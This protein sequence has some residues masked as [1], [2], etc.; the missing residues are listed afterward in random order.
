MGMR[1]NHSKRVISVILALSI[2]ISMMSGFGFT[3]VSAAEAVSVST[4]SALKSALESTSDVDITVTDNIEFT[5]SDASTA[6]SNCIS[7][8]GGKKTLNLNGKGV[9]FMVDTFELMEVSG[10]P[11][12]VITLSGS[13]KLYVTDSV[14]NGIL[15][16]VA[17]DSDYFAF[18]AP[19]ESGGLIS[20]SGT[21]LL[22][23]K[24]SILNNAA[25][26]PCVNVTGDLPIVT[27][28]GATLTTGSSLYSW[29]GG[30]ALSVSESVN[31]PTINLLNKTKLLCSGVNAIQS[32]YSKGSGA[33]YIGNNQAA[34]NVASAVFVGTVQ[35]RVA[36]ASANKIPFMGVATHSVKVDE[37]AKT[38]DASYLTGPESY[39][40]TSGS[41][42]FMVITDNNG[43]YQ[44]ITTEVTHLTDPDAGNTYDSIAN[45]F[46]SANGLTSDG[47]IYNFNSDVAG[48]NLVSGTTYFKDKFSAN[49]AGTGASFSV[50]DDLAAKMNGFAQFYTDT[51][52]SCAGEI[53]FDLKM[54][55]NAI[56]DFAGF[57]IKYGDEIV[58]GTSKNSVFFAND[59][60]RGDSANSTT[61]TTGIGFSFRTI[62]G[63]DCIEI[64]VKYLD[65]TG[66]L[67]V[68]SQYFYDVVD[69]LE[70]FN[71]YKVID[72]GE[73]TVELY[74]NGN[75]F[76]E[77][78]CS[79]AKVPTVNT[80]Y[81]E[82]YYSTAKIL[83]GKGATLATVSNALVSTESALAFGTRNEIIEID[84][85][86]ILS[87]DLGALKINGGMLY[88]AN[89]I[90]AI[91][92]VRKDS[93]DSA[94]FT[95]PIVKA[96]FDGVTYELLPN[97]SSVDSKEY[98]AFTFKNVPIQRMND[99]ISA[100]LY[101]EKDG[102]V[103]ESKS[104][105][106]SVA[107]YAYE[108][109]RT[110]TDSKLK[111]LLVDLLNY[112]SYAQLYTKYNSQ[113]LVNAALT[114]EEAAWGTQELRELV[115]SE[116]KP[117][118][119]GDAVWT[120]IGLIIESK[121][122]IMGYFSIPT[123]MTGVTVRATDS[124]GNLISVIRDFEETQGANGMKN[125][126]FVFDKLTA[127]NMSDVVGFT[128]YNSQGVNIS[129]QY[130]FSIESAAQKNQNSTNAELAD[131]LK[132]MMMYGD[133][134]RAYASNG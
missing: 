77:I 78:V 64:F 94:G 39:E 62:N 29:S 68:S 81:K 74:A 16:Y 95:N 21:A 49:V 126:S 101:A 110:T 66:A 26:G 6:T 127:K 59:G 111:T 18:T 116:F 129:G 90:D 85:I 97:I 25:I 57:Y 120:R 50:T 44:T 15:E 9:S 125:M 51:R 43:N 99:N 48:T 31:M 128:V 106:F 47:Y 84:N 46:D 72:D 80:A 121:V 93:F 32:L 42:Y 133:S 88:L 73:G 123:S 67:S 92:L 115:N 91:L 60:V 117:S 70:V 109:L 30:F 89:A 5:A 114:T 55:P 24:N 17:Y 27:L 4:W 58:S 33:M 53:S 19:K 7:I 45:A 113:N 98:Y 130:L 132:A 102:E 2:V 8:T 103:C 41:G 63:T 76:A 118:S 124:D 86:E 119:V 122:D 10:V 82:T 112:G 40:L 34:V 61:G 54:G 52:W 38:T 23:V 1:T 87:N 69:N 22:N 79:D 105:E 96:E 28:D 13:A 134:A 107:S 131:F 11:K 3:S 83:D 35:A 36:S 104:Y 75:L 108:Q 12:S 20:V 56:N 65:S 71:N 37:L 14:G 100:I